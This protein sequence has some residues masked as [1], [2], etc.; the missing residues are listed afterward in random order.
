MR[1]A[2]L[3]DIHGNSAGLDAA[4]GKMEGCEAMLCCGDLCDPAI[5][6]RMAS[7]FSGP[8]HIVLGNC[9][10]D[11]SGL[12]GSADRHEHVTLHGELGLVELGGAKFALHHFPEVA[13]ALAASERYDVV[14]HGHTHR[15][16]I[17][18]VGRTLQI[19]PGDIQGRYGEAGFV[20]YDTGSGAAEEI[21]F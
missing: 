15:R 20:V 12:T 4:I 5:L 2:I 16:H 10:G 21:D 13:A 14:C 11:R 7:L 9:D 1:V 17:T 8:I 3:S 6:D 18:R 19:N